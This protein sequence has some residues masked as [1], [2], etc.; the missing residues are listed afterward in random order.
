MA[1]ES[2]TVLQARLDSLLAVA[3][4]RFWEAADT[5]RTLYPFP[6]DWMSPEELTEM[7][8]LQLAIVV[9]PDSDNIEKVRA[10]VAAK[11]AARVA[12]GPA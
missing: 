12:G 5:S 4:R 11:R 9:H 3:E 1:D 7:S 8:A 2:L 6:T 10:R